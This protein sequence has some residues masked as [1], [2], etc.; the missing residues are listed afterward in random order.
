[1]YS[2]YV[3]VTLYGIKIDTLLV[4]FF[5]PLYVKLLHPSFFWEPAASKVETSESHTSRRSWCFGQS[6]VQPFS[7]RWFGF[8]SASWPHV[9]FS[10]CTS[11]PHRDRTRQTVALQTAFLPLPALKSRKSSCLGSG[12]MHGVVLR[13]CPFLSDG[14]GAN[15]CWRSSA[16]VQSDHENQRRPPVPLLAQIPMAPKFE[17]SRC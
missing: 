6:Q 4:L 13:I 10:T 16:I 3:V 14:T 12:S 15:W 1:M 8:A 17:E 7:C 2:M 11:T 5:N 9:C